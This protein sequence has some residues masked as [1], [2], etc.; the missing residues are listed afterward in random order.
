MRRQVPYF[1]PQAAFEKAVF[2]FAGGKA[3]R[4]PLSGRVFMVI[5]V[6]G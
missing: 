2:L 1:V 5:V 6:Y 4:D 3:K